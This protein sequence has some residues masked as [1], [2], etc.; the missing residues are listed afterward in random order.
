MHKTCSKCR[1]TIRG[2]NLI[3]KEFYK[4]V[5]TSDGLQNN[6]KGCQGKYTKEYY[7][8]HREYFSERSR[9]KNLLETKAIS[10][11]SFKLLEEKLRKKF[12][13]K[14]RSDD[15]CS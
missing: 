4:D 7:K 11:V 1:K 3:K 10:K 15:K 8:D 6:C 12:K 2:E 9:L 14:G 13:I 5:A